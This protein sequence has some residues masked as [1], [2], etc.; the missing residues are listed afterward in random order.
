MP[1]VSMDPSSDFDIFMFWALILGANNCSKQG[2]MV[3][4][5]HFKWWVVSEFLVLIISGIIIIEIWFVGNSTAM[6]IL[7]IDHLETIQL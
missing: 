7:L 6:I 4:K 3:E 5:T 1:K 2:K